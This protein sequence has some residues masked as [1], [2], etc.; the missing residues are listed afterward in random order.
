MKKYLSIICAIAMLASLTGCGS[1]GS[2]SDSKT[3]S[4]NISASETEE[5]T[6]KET[7]KEEAT[8]EQGTTEEATEKPT[9]APTEEQTEPASSNLSIVSHSLT[10]DYSGADVLV[11]EYSWTNDEDKEEAFYSNVRDSVYQNGVECST[12]VVVDEVE[13]QDQMK[14]VMP[15]T[16]IN[17]KIPYKLQDNTNA[18]VVC[19]DLFGDNTLLDETIEL[20]GGEGAA[21]PAETGDTSLEYVSHR[22]VKDYDGKEVLLVEYDFHNGEKD[23]DSFTLTINDSAY[24]NGVECDDDV[25]GVDEINTEMHIADIQPGVTQRIVVGYHIKDHSPVTLKATRAFGSKEYLNKTI[26][27]G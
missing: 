14:K 6:E 8:P 9:E 20:G 22:I 23:A 11:I 12:L 3:K 26:E 24:Q 15:G 16:T 2:D 5:K 1:S 10:K 17:I 19:T 25:F 13:S 18:H 7:E 21:V 27:I 4:S